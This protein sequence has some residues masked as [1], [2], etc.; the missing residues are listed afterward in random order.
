[1]E[2]PVARPFFS[3]RDIED[4]MREVGHI[5]SSGVLISGPYTSQL[6]DSFREYCGVRH[7]VAVSTGTAALEITLGYFGVKGK[8]VIVPTST[9]ISTGNAVI[10]AGGTLCSLT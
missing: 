9:F 7:A 2:L 3:Q 8:E 4:I 6:E 10:Y 5:L 1:M